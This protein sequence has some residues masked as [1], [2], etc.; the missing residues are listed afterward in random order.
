MAD[1]LETLGWDGFE[2]CCQIPNQSAEKRDKLLDCLG[3]QAILFHKKEI[4]SDDERYK[5]LKR[6]RTA[7]KHLLDVYCA[8]DTGSEVG[9]FTLP[10]H[11]SH[12]MKE[13]ADKVYYALERHW[14]CNCSQRTVKSSGAREARLSLIR[15]RQMGIKKSNWMDSKPASDLAKFEVLLPICKDDVDWKATNIEVRHNRYDEKFW[16]QYPKLQLLILC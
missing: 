16:I 6:I 15:H 14:R 2:E 4:P 5:F 12:G 9:N 11:P 3:R 7:A 10:Q 1:R 8:N 13:L